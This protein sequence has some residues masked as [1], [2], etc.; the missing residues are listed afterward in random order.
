LGSG[1]DGTGCLGRDLPA[2]LYT[3]DDVEEG[4]HFRTGGI[5]VTE[6]HVVGFAGLTGDLFDLH[7]D[8]VFARELG[9][10]RRVAHGIL[11]LALTDGLKNRA[12]V[13]L[14]SVASLEWSWAFKAPILI[15]DRVAA[16]IEILSK[17]PTR[18]PDR[19]ILGLGFTVRNQ[20]GLVVQEGRNQLMVLTGKAV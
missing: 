19:G 9:F 3:F 8:D 15:G 10:E 1:G 4:D 6:S 20:A 2:G 18:R 12:P 5:V 14:A 16:E 7:M 11:G 13:R 17:R